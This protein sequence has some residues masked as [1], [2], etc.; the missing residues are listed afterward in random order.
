MLGVAGM[1]IPEALTAAG[2]LDVPVWYDTG[3]AEFWCP[4]PTLFAIEFILFNFVELLRWQD[5]KK[6]GSVS[7]DPFGNTLA[8][9][10]VGYPGFNPMGLG[11]D[12]RSKESEI[13]NGQPPTLYLYAQQG[14]PPLK[15]T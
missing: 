14:N 6:P 3:V 13:A 11:T 12:F 9:G 2:I 8:P 15:K 1:I 5:I 4:T 7:T 10:E